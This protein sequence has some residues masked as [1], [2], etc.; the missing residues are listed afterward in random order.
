MVKNFNGNFIKMKNI[1]SVILVL[2]GVYM[3]YLGVKGGIQPP[4]VTGI[5][6]IVI[7][8]LFYFGKKQ[9]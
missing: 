8:A 3:I 1:L 2:L 4:T 9:D 6:F 5:G 7:A